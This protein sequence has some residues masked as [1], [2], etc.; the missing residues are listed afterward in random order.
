MKQENERLKKQISNSTTVYA[1]I[2]IAL[3]LALIMGFVL[4]R[5]V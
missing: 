5:L 1:K 2:I 3:V 4:S